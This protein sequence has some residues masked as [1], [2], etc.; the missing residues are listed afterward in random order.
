[1]IT[2]YMLITAKKS[3]LSRINNSNNNRTPDQWSSAHDPL[4]C[5]MAAAR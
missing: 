5:K 2:Q 4:P 3:K 1:M